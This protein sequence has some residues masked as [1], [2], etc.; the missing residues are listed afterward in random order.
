MGLYTTLGIIGAYLLLSL[1]LLPVQ[2]KYV[3]HL[4]EEDKKR[5]EIGLSQAEYYDKMSFENQELHY[6]AQGN[7]LFIG[8]NLLAT[9]LY[10]WKHKKLEY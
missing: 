3:K 4:K 9:L 5:K 1:I 10:K 7:I 8:A 6:N 2:Y